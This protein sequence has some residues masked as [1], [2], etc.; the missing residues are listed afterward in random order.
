MKAVET[1]VADVEKA[2]KL[3]SDD[4]LVGEASTMMG[5]QKDESLRKLLLCL[6]SLLV[7][8]LEELFSIVCVWGGGGGGIDIKAQ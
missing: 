3:I 5:N 7:L 8:Y 2:L 4:L 6:H 1:V